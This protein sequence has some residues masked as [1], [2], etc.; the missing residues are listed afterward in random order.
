MG[1]WPFARSHAS[2]DA[3]MLLER[4]QSASRQPALY[5][6]GRVQDT[7][8]GRFEAL[9][10]FASLALMRLRSDPAAEPL[11]QHFTDILF[12]SIDSGLREAGVGDLTVPKKIR[13]LASGFYGRLEAYSEAVQSKDGPALAAAIERNFAVPGA[14]AVQLASQ[15]LSTAQRQANGPVGALL[16]PW[17]AAAA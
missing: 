3:E 11:A 2:R 7:L 9:T 1:I 8:E 5:G 4:V 15:A 13:A 10:L 12:R 6:A 17:P 14:F 16:E